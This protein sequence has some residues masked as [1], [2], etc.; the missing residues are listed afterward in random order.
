MGRL[1][2]LRILLCGLVTGVTWFM[3]DAILLSAFARPFVAWIGATNGGARWNTGVD[4]GIDLAMGVWAMWMYSVLRAHHRSG[5]RT[6]VVTGV[7]WWVIKTLQSAK[8]AS[9]GLIPIGLIPLPLVVTLFAAIGASVVGGQLYDRVK[10]PAG[11][12]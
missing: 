5:V 12:S 3:L 8:W 11:S 1:N 7:S 9:L 10:L 2:W 4:F 6:A